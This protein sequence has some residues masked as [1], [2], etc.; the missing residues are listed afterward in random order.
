MIARRSWSLWIVLAAVALAFLPALRGEFNWDD[1]L[2]VENNPL[3]AAPLPRGAGAIFTSVVASNYHPVTI[4]S[5]ALDYRLGGSE[6]VVYHLTNVVLHLAN[7]ALVY[8]LVYRLS[9]SRSAA[10]VAALMF[11]I[12][13][14]RVE[15][16]AWISGRKDLL[17]AFFYL[18]SLLAYL[19]HARGE[20]PAGAYLASVGLFVLSLLSKGMAVSL[21]L[22]VVLVDYLLGRRVS[23]RT[24]LEKIPF[25]ALAILFG[26]L[27]I[28]A[29]QTTGAMEHDLA[30]PL[31]ER[32]QLA[33]FGLSLYLGKHFLPL[34]LSAVYP[35][36]EYV[37]GQL[38]ARFLVYPALI[39]G[40]TVSVA[41]FA[42]RRRKIV[43][44]VLFFLLNVAPVA[45]LVPVGA[46]VAAD[47]YTY[48]ASIGLAWLAGEGYACLRRRPGFA[49]PA[50]AAV[51]V[52][53]LLLGVATWQ[54]SAV[55]K[56]R[57]TL[58][59]DVIAKYPR[60]H[61][62]FDIRGLERSNRGDKAGAIADFDEALRLR[63]DYVRAYNN[64]GNARADTGDLAGA[65]RDFD[66]AI[67]LRPEFGL[68]HY[69]RGH[70]LG[71]LGNIEGAIE[72]MSLAIRYS[73]GLA[74]AY[75][76]RGDAQ[77]WLGRYDAAIRD[78]DVALSLDPGNAAVYHGRG[79]AYDRKGDP[80]RA[81]S[82]LRQAA[83]LG[84]P[85]DGA[86]LRRLEREAS[87]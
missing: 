25:F 87:P 35:Y 9:G 7:V 23:R 8:L 81:L 10:W 34:G 85:V 80:V 26:V 14:L 45:Q 70:L 55:W 29:Q 43:F 32:I 76:N 44:C 15:S 40:L 37:V 50:T 53:A 63:P 30:R 71:E 58:F 47:R 52:A 65:L 17:Y 3:L 66:R 28:W 51:V 56:N 68:A 83:R 77:R 75:L 36:P 42:R 39:V 78:Y 62:A 31:A 49:A 18:A 2:Y 48:V 6:P 82:D 38:P 60:F 64:R 4:L 86:R 19:R 5:L 1:D 46:A 24:V 57:L 13:P 84:Y 21:S 54:R 72:E 79:E 41:L 67:E 16:V 74:P 27:A 12:H 73:P 69:N 11:G 22:V 20:R 59:G 33:G 61:P